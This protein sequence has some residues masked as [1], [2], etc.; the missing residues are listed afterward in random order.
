MLS[1]AASQG[2]HVSSW[3]P[4]ERWHPGTYAT[5]R[6]ASGRDAHA[7]SHA[8]VPAVIVPLQ[9]QSLNGLFIAKHTKYIQYSYSSLGTGSVQPPQCKWVPTVLCRWCRCPTP[10]D[11]A[12]TPNH[13]CLPGTSLG[14]VA[15]MDGSP[16]NPCGRGKHSSCLSCKVQDGLL[17]KKSPSGFWLP[18][19]LFPAPSLS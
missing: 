10:T 15:T 18:M 12:K 1:P 6:P 2:A 16:C 5:C 3:L 9:G 7:D 8:H 11:R 13:S 19:H 14:F 17:L 4:A